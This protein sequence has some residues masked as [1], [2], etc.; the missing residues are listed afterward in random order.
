MEENILYLTRFCGVEQYPVET[1]TWYI[2]DGDGTED[3][4][5]ILC[6]KAE[7]TAGNHLHEDTAYI[8]AEPSWEVS[9]CAARIP[10]HRLQPGFCLE[11]PNVDKDVDGNLYYMEHQPTTDNEME[12][13]A[14][15]GERLK[16]R[17]KGFTED[18]NYCDGS[19]PQ[20]RMQL[21]AWFRKIG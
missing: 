12:I 3:E 13:L 9:F 1:A 2:I 19:K 11:Q 7:C 8:A 16:I 21:T 5:D 6:I 18:V 20:N 14:V 4:P 17:L 15:E 10:I